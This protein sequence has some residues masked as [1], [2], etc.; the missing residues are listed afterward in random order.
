MHVLIDG[1][2]I[3]F[4]A[5]CT[6]E[7]PVYTHPEWGEWRLKTPLKNFFKHQFDDDEYEGLMSEVVES[8]VTEPI[9]NTYKVVDNLIA[10][11]MRE[12]DGTR[13]TLC[14]KGTA[15]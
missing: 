6:T 5:C 11:I 1:D 2:I 14:L 8:K 13:Y 15:P 3:A 9:K 7:Y 4:K 12:T 10:T